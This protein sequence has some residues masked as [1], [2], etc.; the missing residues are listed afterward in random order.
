MTEPFVPTAPSPEGPFPQS[1]GRYR[2]E[3]RLGAGAH[4]TVYHAFDTTLRTPVAVKIPNPQARQHPAMLERFYR[5]ARAGARLRQQSHLCQILDVGAYDGIPYLTM[6][7][8]D[9][10]PLR[11]RTPWEPGEAARLVWKL[12]RA[13]DKA[14]CCG[15]VHRDLKPDNVLIDGSG[16]PTIT[17]FGVALLLGPDEL[18]STEPGTV[19]GTWLYAAP[20]QMDGQAGASGVACDVYSLG[21]ILYEL[22]VGRPPFLSSSITD[23][24]RMVQ[25]DEPR[26]P[27]ELRPELD[28]D[29]G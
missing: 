28:P 12:A 4:G 13:L 18:R 6:Q 19:I 23:L 7:L 26:D 25:N 17:D 22:L 8:I 10:R 15:V 2:L 16:E 29:L 20:E 5:E 21:V 24:I 9:G 1:F 27:C 3:Q 11:V 14:H